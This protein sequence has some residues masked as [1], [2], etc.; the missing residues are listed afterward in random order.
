[1]PVYIDTHNHVGLTEVSEDLEAF[2][3][4]CREAGIRSGVITTG[5]VK[6]FERVSQVAQKLHWGYCVGLHPLYISEDYQADL[7]SLK[8]FLTTH[9][10]DEYL[11]GIGEIG[12]DFYVEGLNRVNQEKVFEAELQLAQSFNL[13]VSVHS[14]RALYRVMALMGRY[15][16]VRGA[17]HAFSGSS[18]ELKQA[19]KRGYFLGFGG[20]MT[21]SGSKRVRQAALL[22]PQDRLLLETDAPDMAPSFSETGHSSSLFLPRYLE[23]LSRLRNE[24]AELLGQKI[25]ENSL[26]AFPRMRRFVSF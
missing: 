4:K 26:N 8:E 10:D 17:L 6:D 18:E 1:M 2:A 13:S 15:P 14:R 7:Q 24:S 3:Q 16:E 9:L 11:V 23:E 5:T 22:C 19:V 21:Y 25:F 20:A 12:L